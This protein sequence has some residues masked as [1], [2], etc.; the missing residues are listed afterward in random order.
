MPR[1]N[2][3]IIDYDVVL[4]IGEWVS[5]LAKVPQIEVETHKVAASDVFVQII[6]TLG[7]E[8]LFFTYL[9]E[10]KTILLCCI[11]GSGK[12]LTLFAIVA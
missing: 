6:D 9:T 5:W 3:S 7:H 12:T 2:T 10:H 8:N 1:G 4:T 11:P